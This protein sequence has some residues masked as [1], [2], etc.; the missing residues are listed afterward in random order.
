MS[1]Y[2]KF[3]LV[4]DQQSRSPG[5]QQSEPF[6]EPSVSSD[7]PEELALLG[8]VGDQCNHWERARGPVPVEFDDLGHAPTLATPVG[9]GEA[10]P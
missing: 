2:R 7:Q 4:A 5:G 1:S 9:G 8:I 10:P 3:E 6:E